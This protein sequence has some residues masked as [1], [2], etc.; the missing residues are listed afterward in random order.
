MSNVK[1]FYVIVLKEEEDM[2]PSEIKCVE[3]FNTLPEAKSLRYYTPNGERFDASPY[4]KQKEQGTILINTMDNSENEAT[5]Y[6]LTK[7]G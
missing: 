2:F 3:S 5:I 6:R 1:V 4:E 7:K